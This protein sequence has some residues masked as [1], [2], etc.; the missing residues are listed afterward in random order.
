MSCPRFS[1]TGHSEGDL[2]HFLRVGLMRGA[3][4]KEAPRILTVEAPA[5]RRRRRGHHREPRHLRPI[6]VDLSK[7]FGREM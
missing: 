7:H 3:T 4:R 1:R 6:G 5:G 2:R